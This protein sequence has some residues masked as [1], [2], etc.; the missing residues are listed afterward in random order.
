[1]RP[2]VAS[3]ESMLEP[4]LRH[5]AAHLDGLDLPGD[6]LVTATLFTRSAW[7]FAATWLSDDPPALGRPLAD[8]EA[9]ET[10]TSFLHA[11][12]GGERPHAASHGRG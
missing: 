6:P 11:G 1:M 3:G 4:D 12:L 9:I 2:P 5:I 7:A 8:E 10:L